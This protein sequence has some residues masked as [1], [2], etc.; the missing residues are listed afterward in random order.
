MAY[1]VKDYTTKKA[2]AEDVK[3]GVRVECYDNSV[4]RQDLTRFTGEVT[5]EGPHFPRA[6]TWYATAQLKDGAV[7]KVR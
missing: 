2:L 1:T 6:H 4:A 5:L 7:V 3:R